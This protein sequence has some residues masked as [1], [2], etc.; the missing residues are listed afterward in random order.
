[1]YSAPPPRGD[2]QRI[3][4]APH[5]GANEY[6]MKPFDK[7]IATAGIPGSRPDLVPRSIRG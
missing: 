6:I 4:R 3:A 7:D 5:A 1:M 2:V